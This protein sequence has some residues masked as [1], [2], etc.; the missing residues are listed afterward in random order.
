[1]SDPIERGGL[2]MLDGAALVTGAAVASVHFR[3]FA[4]ELARLDLRGWAMVSVAYTWLALTSAG[5]FVFLV[6][7]SG[8]RPSGYPGV[9]DVSW[10]AIG[11]P[12]LIAALFISAS[13]GSFNPANGFYTNALWIALYVVSAI[14][15]VG[16]LRTW[17]AVG[18][19]PQ[20]R[21]WT[22]AVGR[23]IAATWPLQLGLGFVVIR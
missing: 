16:L 2:T 17:P 14:G 19:K 5:P 4:G 21:S 23:A 13:G 11:S 20:R 1:M 12:W 18:P 7:R 22:D 15:M 10:L 6:R 8:R 9:G 3:E